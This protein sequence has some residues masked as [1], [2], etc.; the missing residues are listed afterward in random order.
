MTILALSG[1]IFQ[2]MLG[3]VLPAAA[4]TSPASAYLI[5]CSADDATR[6]VAIDADGQPATNAA[7]N[8]HCDVCLIADLGAGGLSENAGANRYSRT[9]EQVFSGYRSVDLAGRCNRHTMDT[10]T[11]V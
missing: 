3:L 10:C 7:G 4:V 2:I 8:G 11:P 1:M 5:L 6:T 9:A